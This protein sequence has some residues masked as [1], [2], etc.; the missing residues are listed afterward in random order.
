MK[1]WI[2]QFDTETQKKLYARAY[3]YMTYRKAYYGDN[4]TV[5]DALKITNKE[6]IKEMKMNDYY[7]L[8]SLLDE[9]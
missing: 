7:K 1:D 3:D 4:L 5:E 6:T 8:K 9:F 2:K